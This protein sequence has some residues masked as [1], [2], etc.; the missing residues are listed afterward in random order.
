MIA[1]VIIATIKPGHMEKVVQATQEHVV[2]DLDEIDGLE[3]FYVM[4]NNEDNTTLTIAVYDNKENML[5]QEQ[6]G[7]LREKMG[8]MMNLAAKQPQIAYYEV[9]IKR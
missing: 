7:W 6:S 8:A 3:S 4:I 9:P 1:R 5:K 2:P